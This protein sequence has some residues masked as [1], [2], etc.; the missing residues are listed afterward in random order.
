MDLIFER[1]PKKHRRGIPWISAQPEDLDFTHDVALRPHR[2]FYTHR[3]KTS[4]LTE[5]KIGKAKT[6]MMRINEVKNIELDGN[7]NCII[8]KYRPCIAQ[9]CQQ[10]RGKDQDT[11]KSWKDIPAAFKMLRLTWNSHSISAKTKERNFYTNVA[12]V[13]W[14]IAAIGWGFCGAL[15]FASNPLSGRIWCQMKSCGDGFAKNLWHCWFWHTSRDSLATSFANQTPK[16]PTMPSCDRIQKRPNIHHLEGL[17]GQSVS[18][19]RSRT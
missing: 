7:N 18:V 5:L 6:R 11:C 13:L 17:H 1:T 16:W 3:R 15:T 9:Y 4:A 2:H 10:R 8:P 12:S 14:N 19:E